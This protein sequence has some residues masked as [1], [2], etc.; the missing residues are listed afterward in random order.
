VYALRSDDR[1][2]TYEILLALA[3]NA[4]PIGA[5][6]L[7][8]QLG[9]KL[10]LG[11]ATIGRKLLEMDSKG[12][13]VKRGLQGRE[14]SDH[15]RTHLNEIFRE[16]TLEKENQQFIQSLDA[17][18]K[19]RL[20]EVL[21]V[22]R[23]IESEAARL[24]AQKCTPD[25]IGAMEEVL[26][27]QAGKIAKEEP[28]TDEDL[29]F[30]DLVAHASSNSVL[31]DVLVIIRR[32]SQLSPL[33]ATI[34]QKVGGRLLSEHLEILKMMKLRA[35]DSAAEAMAQHI[36]SLAKDVEMFWDQTHHKAV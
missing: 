3:N 27:R 35:P 1:V 28:G 6:T 17:G 16:M 24:A 32:A 9:P 2:V 33:V 34:R 26:N 10:G 19:E 20:L 25:M 21:A 13:T 5:T 29:E 30:H 15:G 18:T 31:K 8:I 23:I 22:R 11:Q 12:F 36:G 4:G 7:N 14:I